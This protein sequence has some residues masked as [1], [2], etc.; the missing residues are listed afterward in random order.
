MLREDFRDICLQIGHSVYVVFVFVVLTIMF[1]YQ[2]SDVKPAAA[3][4]L[5]VRVCLCVS[6]CLRVIRVFGSKIS[7]KLFDR[8]L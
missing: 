1:Y 2:P 4:N 6:V 7:Q 8:L 5:L 3:D